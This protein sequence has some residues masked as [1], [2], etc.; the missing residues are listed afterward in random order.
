MYSYYDLVV[1]TRFH[2]VI[3]ALNVETPA[4]AIAYGGYK[5]TGI[6]A[7]IGLSEYVIPIEQPD[8]SLLIKMVDQ[9]WLRES[10]IKDK[11]RAYREVLSIERT[12]LVNI[13]K[14]DL[15]NLS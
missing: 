2:S 3:F 4:I 7:D 6:M 13:L 8:A 1:G 15:A 14:Q 9:V 5:A 12:R 10:E 11:I